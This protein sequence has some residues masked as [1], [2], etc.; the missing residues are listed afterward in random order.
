M[1]ILLPLFCLIYINADAQKLRY[2]KRVRSN[3]IVVDTVDVGYA[4][5]NGAQ[6]YVSNY[7]NDINNGTSVTTPFSSIA[8]INSL[9][10]SAGDSIHFKKGH[11]FTGSIVVKNNGNYAKRITF[12]N[13]GKQGSLPVIN[14]FVSAKGFTNVGGN[15]WQSSSITTTVMPNMVT[16][17]GVATPLGRT[18]NTGWAT[19][20]TVTGTTAI[21]DNLLTGTP[22]YTGAEIVQR[23]YHWFCTRDS[24]TNHTGNSI[25][26]SPSANIN[27]QAGWGYYI[28]KS[29]ACLDVQNEWY[30]DAA[31]RKITIYS[32]AAPTNVKISVTDTLVNVAKNSYITV[33]D[34]ALD[35]ANAAG[36][37]VN[38]ALYGNNLKDVSIK[39]CTITNSGGDGIFG[40]NTDSL[41]VDNN[42]IIVTHNSGIN[43]RSDDGFS[44]AGIITNNIVRKVNMDIGMGR[45]GLNG[46]GIA[47]AGPFSTV[48][49]NTLDS[50]GFNGIAMYYRFCT[51]DSN[52]VSNYCMRMDDGAGLYFY[53]AFADSANKVTGNVVVGG[54]GAPAGTGDGISGGGAMGIYFDDNADSFVVSGNTIA[55]VQHSGFFLH[56]AKRINMQNNTVYNAGLYNINMTHDQYGVNT[57]LRGNT[58]KNNT[59]LA[60][61]PTT[62][63]EIST[64]RND[65]D[66]MGV[67]DNNNYVFAGGYF[68]KFHTTKTVSGSAV[69]GGPYNTL[70]AWQA[71]S[72][73]YDPNSLAVSRSGTLVFYYNGTKTAAPVSLGPSGVLDVAGS[74]IG[75]G[76]F[77]QPFQSRIFWLQ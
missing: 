30:F 67:K 76:Y 40:T 70:A 1:K 44:T 39:N 42:S 75:G 37:A 61:T 9:T 33:T 48:K 5:P 45:T 18:P 55:N 3:V 52:F 13:Y 71:A 32:A 24:I 69:G 11:L 72:S 58:F 51:T 66:S 68:N 19:N 6:Y 29:L 20:T 77:L 54:I 34:L 26:Y 50:I 31:T 7:G 15:L 57:P 27:S 46:L 8:K 36:V 38:H 28:Q 59:L 10:L 2:A 23:K 53:P 12:C 16:I 21:T 73:F 63:V 35:G 65:L 17:N 49:F 14:G 56:N 22:N 64:I 74:I 4:N 41:F 62:Q 25:T 60:Y 43:I 47:H